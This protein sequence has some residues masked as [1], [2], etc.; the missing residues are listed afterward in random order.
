MITD[1]KEQSILENNSLK[2]K[3]SSYESDFGV[4]SEAILLYHRHGNDLFADQYVSEKMGLSSEMIRQKIY[5]FFHHPLEEAIIHLDEENIR[6]RIALTLQYLR[7]TPLPASP[8]QIEPMT[9]NETEA[10][11]NKLI[12]HYRFSQTPLG[13]V[14]VASSGKGVCY[15]A[16]NDNDKEYAVHQLVKR[17]PGVKLVEEE[18]LFQEEALS[19]F[20]AENYDG[21]IIH[22][23]LRATEFQIGAWKKL[24]MIPAGGLITYSALAGNKKY[25]HATGN[26]VGSN[27]IAYLIPCHRAVPASGKSGEYHWGKAK[28]AALICMEALRNPLSYQSKTHGLKK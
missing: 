12:I 24:L 9:E 23:H 25:S 27:P 6:Q 3:F 16:F 22:L 18:D 1:T 15:L 10:T 4:I 11:K 19:A 28:K 7:E 26:A 8:V 20:D 14:I 13:S 2:Q 21:H 5:D 17:F